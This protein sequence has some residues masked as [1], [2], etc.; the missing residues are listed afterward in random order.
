[1]F[2]RYHFPQEI[3]YEYSGGVVENMDAALVRVSCDNGEYGLGEITHGE[4]CYEPVIGTIEHFK[5]FLIGKPVLEIN[6]AWQDMYNSSLFWN[7]Q[8]LGIGVMGGINIA[9]YDLAGKILKLPVYQL[10]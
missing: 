4:F 2:L 6:R 3:S 9:M 7:R 1:M 10:L 8:G 5:N